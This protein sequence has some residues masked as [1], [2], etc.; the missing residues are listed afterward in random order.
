MERALTAL[1]DTRERPAGNLRITAGEHAT[2][3][4][5]WPALKPF[6]LQYPDINIEITVDNGLTDIVDGRFDAGVRL[7]EQVAKEMI[8]VRIA[9]DMRMAVVGSPAYLQQA[10]TPQT[11]WGSCA[12][13][14]HQSAPADTR[15]TLRLGVCPR[16]PGYPGPGGGASDPQQP[17]AAHR[18]GGGGAS[19]W[20]TFRMTRVAEALASGR[21]VQ[22]LADWTPTFPGY[23]LSLPQS[24]PAYQ[25]FHSV[26][27]NL[28]DA[29]LIDKSVKCYR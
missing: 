20:P 9:P 19:V 3:T 21:L 16:R 24:T 15:W 28:C 29:D 11:P 23:H 8:A 18:C 1:R 7:G 22:V 6:M 12:A 13:S 14:L 25:R 17:A 10:G 2:S 26:A 27:G 4:V 5:L